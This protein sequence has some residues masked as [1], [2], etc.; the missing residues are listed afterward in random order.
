MVRRPKVQPEA[1]LALEYFLESRHDCPGLLQSVEH[2]SIGHPV[3]IDVFH[4]LLCC[5]ET[6]MSRPQDQRLHDLVLVV[7]V[8]LLRSQNQLELLDLHE[9]NARIILIAAQ[10][11]C[12]GRQQA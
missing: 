5:L 12:N 1:A 11:Q 8:Q 7:H 10:V 9:G 2:L 6:V 3:P 4:E